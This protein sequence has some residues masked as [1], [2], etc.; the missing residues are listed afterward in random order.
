[1]SHKYWAFI[2]YSSKDRSW[3]EWLI[4]ALERYPIPR[5]LVGLKAGQGVIPRRL[6]PVFRDRDELRA[7]ADVGEELRR[8]LLASRC[9]V[10][11]CSPHSAA[12]TSW[13]GREITLFKQA[14]RQDD[15][16]AMIVDGEPNASDSAREC[17]P[18]PLRRRFDERGQMTELPVDPLASDVRRED[19]RARV[20]RR[21][22]LLK[23]VARI[24]DV[25]FDTLER[26]DRRRRRQ[27]AA[28][29]AAGIAALGVVLALLAGTTLDESRTALSHRIAQQARDQVDARTEL[30]A[31]WSVLADRVAPTPAAYES[32]LAAAQ[33]NPNLV[34]QLHPGGQVRAVAF[35]ADDATIAVAAC[36]G[37]TGPCQVT[38]SSLATLQAQPPVAIGGRISHL[39]FRP[40]HG[41]WLIAR[42]EGQV[43]EVLAFDPRTPKAPPSLLYRDQRSFGALEV[44]GDGALWA[45]AADGGSD[46]E[47]FDDRGRRCGA[48][49]MS[50]VRILAFSPDGKH[51]AAAGDREVLV[52]DLAPGVACAQSRRPVERLPSDVSFSPASDALLAIAPDGTVSQWALP[53]ERSQ[54]RSFNLI[55]YSAEGY[56]HAFDRQGRV[57]AS[58]HPDHVRVYDLEKRRRILAELAEADGERQKDQLGR[59]L[60]NVELSRLRN[61]VPQQMVFSPSGKLIATTDAQ[62]TVAV[63]TASPRPIVQATQDFAAAAP[64]ESIL[65]ATSPDG[66]LRATVRTRR[67]ACD[68]DYNDDCRVWTELTLIDAGSGLAIARLSGPNDPDHS[69]GAETAVAFRPDGN[70]VVR[71]GFTSETWQVARGSLLRWACRVANRSLTDDEMRGFF[72]GPWHRWLRPGSLCA[73]GRP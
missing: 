55:T 62:G 43:A 8:A 11:V 63:W 25:D 54:D 52:L 10:V 60:S 22:A 7:G 61:V 30:A 13:V 64:G 17:F 51:L 65:E 28:S 34:T 12:P 44:S 57:L 46:L 1:L 27:R 48:A 9:L 33:S 23:L 26:R 35:D 38:V 70:V 14:G 56:A 5:S 15:V 68:S 19:S 73:T 18:L 69:F 6:F 36:T 66:R 42:T 45:V 31:L 37:A 29:W 53:I 16:L 59:E 4:R 3:G 39:R 67:E 40:G 49:L 2:S 41:Q 24:I 50:P 71:R 47:V 58:K 20:S 32:L 72:A 21:K